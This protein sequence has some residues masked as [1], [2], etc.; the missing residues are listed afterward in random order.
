MRMCVYMYFWFNIK[1]NLPRLNYVW[2]TLQFLLYTY[3]LLTTWMHWHD[4]QN[5]QLHTLGSSD[6][7][8]KV[9]LVLLEWHWVQTPSPPPAILYF[10]FVLPPIVTYRLLSLCL[11]SRGA[12][13]GKG[14]LR[15][16]SST[17]TSRV[18]SILWPWV[19]TPCPKQQSWQGR[20]GGW[21][22]GGGL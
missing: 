20:G 16:A 6:S 14:S 22:Q 1:I 19:S 5:L 13:A 4:P 15:E 8:R 7:N 17:V 2:K 12:T 11:L 3:E 10:F 9:T 18:T 21:G